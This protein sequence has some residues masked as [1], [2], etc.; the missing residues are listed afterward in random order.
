MDGS[1]VSTGKGLVAKIDGSGDVGELMQ[2]RL[3]RRWHHKDCE[4]HGIYDWGIEDA[5]CTSPD[6][7][8]ADLKL[9]EAE[10]S[11]IS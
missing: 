8:L 2:V 5:R 10:M 11:I 1:I 9:D 7:F 6:S 3:C 4:L